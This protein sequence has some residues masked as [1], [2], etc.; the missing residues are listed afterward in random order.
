MEAER[1]REDGDPARMSTGLDS[2]EG[3]DGLGEEEIGL[4]MATVTGISPVP[5]LGCGG[6]VEWQM[7]VPIG[8]LS[9]QQR[10]HCFK[11]GDIKVQTGD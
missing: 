4:A 2:L 9:G 11:D 7:E 8:S 10:K 1:E 6:G 3:E 5:R